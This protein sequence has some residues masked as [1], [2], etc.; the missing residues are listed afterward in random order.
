[1]IRVYTI[2]VIEHLTNRKNGKRNVMKEKNNGKHGEQKNNHRPAFTN[3]D[4]KK[5][6]T[7]LYDFFTQ[8]IK[9]TDTKANEWVNRR[10]QS[11]KTT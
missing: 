1:M 9:L 7:E 10:I 8:E 6:R 5:I 3:K 11:L 4:L 2:V